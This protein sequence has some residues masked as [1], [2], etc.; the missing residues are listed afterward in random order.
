VREQRGVRV[1]RRGKRR[2]Q[3]AERREKTAQQAAPPKQWLACA[4]IRK[5]QCGAVL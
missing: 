2:E 4:A 3:R 5:G 1:E